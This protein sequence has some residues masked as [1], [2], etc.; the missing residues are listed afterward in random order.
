[1]LLLGGEVAEGFGMFAVQAVRVSCVRSREGV[2]L[3]ENL[4]GLSI[5]AF[6]GTD[7][8]LVFGGGE[9]FSSRLRLCGT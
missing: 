6:W 2:L 4:F 1:M 5:F 8:W 7:K 3:E 9:L